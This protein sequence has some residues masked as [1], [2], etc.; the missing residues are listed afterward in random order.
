MLTGDEV[1]RARL[2]ARLTQE[3]L[4][5]KVGRSQRSIGNWERTKGALPADVEATFRARVPDLLGGP[6]A[7]EQDHPLASVSDARLLAEIARRFDR[8]RQE[9]DGDDAAPTNQAPLTAVP[10][11]GED[12]D[13]P[14]PADL[15][16]YDVQPERPYDSQLPEHDDD[17]GR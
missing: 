12:E 6:T 9:R 14:P 3:Q 7:D 4:G 16:A 5:Q 13:M 10:A 15:A 17:E 2:R 1:R 8:G 11:I